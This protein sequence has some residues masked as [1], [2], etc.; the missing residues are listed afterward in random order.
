[1]FRLGLHLRRYPRQPRPCRR[2]QQR[3]ATELEWDANLA[4]IR[5][6]TPRCG[7]CWQYFTRGCP[8]CD[9]KASSRAR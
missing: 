6:S 9:P 1:M 2:A 3:L 5:A 7:I 4:A 8:G